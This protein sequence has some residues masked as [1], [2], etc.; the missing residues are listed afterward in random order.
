[1][2]S[3]M[4]MRDLKL[5]DEVTVTAPAH[6]WLGFVAAYSQCEWNSQYATAIAAEAQEAMADPLWIKE[7]EAAH[8]KMYAEH[9]AQVIGAFPFPF[10]FG[11]PQD[12]QVPPDT[13]GLE[14]P[15]EPNNT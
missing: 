15:G 4:K 2:T 12:P 6:I 9:N 5:N 1:M 10:N 8:Q 14:D 7:T 3:Y 11:N 13:R